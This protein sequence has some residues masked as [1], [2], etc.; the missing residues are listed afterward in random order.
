MFSLGY[1]RS[2]SRVLP[3]VGPHCRYPA[4]RPAKTYPAFGLT[5]DTRR[6]ASLSLPGAQARQALGHAIDDQVHNNTHD[7]YPAL[8]PGA[9]PRRCEARGHSP[10]APPWKAGRARPPGLARRWGD[11]AKSALTADTRRSASLSLPGAQA[12]QALGHAIDDQVHSDTHDGY[13]A[14]GR[15]GQVRPHPHYPAFRPQSRFGKLDSPSLLSRAEGVM[16]EDYI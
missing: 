13:P 6:S 3:G 15:N 8:G 1:N 10:Q 4:F 7:D 9:G 2:A 16:F 12:R 14:L 5:D 11:T